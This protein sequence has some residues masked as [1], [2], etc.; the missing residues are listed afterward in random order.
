MGYLQSP[1]VANGS[2]FS[3]LVIH[4]VGARRACVAGGG[5]WLLRW[6]QQAYVWPSPRL[7]PRST[8]FAYQSLESTMGLDWQHCSRV[9]KSRGHLPLI[10]NAVNRWRVPLHLETVASFGLLTI[11]G[12][13]EWPVCRWALAL[14]NVSTRMLDITEF[15]RIYICFSK[16]RYS[17]RQGFACQPFE[18]LL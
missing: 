18:Y 3:T 7:R 10:L 2:D 8:Q 1:L 15:S 9:I 13:C 16:N 6:L 4:F 12:C 11:G 14:H 5:H 17:V